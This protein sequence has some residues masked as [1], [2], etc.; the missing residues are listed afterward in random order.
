M[1]QKPPVALEATSIRWA[2]GDPDLS[3]TAHV[4][5]TYT[6]ITTAQ[7]IKVLSEVRAV[8]RVIQTS[9]IN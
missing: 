8:C 3:P 5:T 1:G 4:L 7:V 9:L 2:S 6:V